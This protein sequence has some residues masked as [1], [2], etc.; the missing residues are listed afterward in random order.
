MAPP[1]R[2]RKPTLLIIGGAEDRVGQGDRA[3]PLR[4]ARGGS[5]GQ[6]R[7]HP[8]GVVLPGRGDRGLHRGL[9]PA[10]RPGAVGRQPP[11]PPGRLT[12]RPLVA[13]ID[14]ATGVFMS[15]GSQ[16]KLSQRFPGT[17]LGDALHRAHDRGA[18]IGGTSA[19]AS[20]MSQF[21]ISMGDE[22]ITP[23][24]RAQ[25]AQRRARARSRAS[26]STSTSPSASRY[27]RLMSMVAASPN[28]IG[29][30]HRRGHRRSRSATAGSSRS[31]APAPSSSSTAARP[32]PTR[33]TPAVER[34]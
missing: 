14:E 29:I 28:L 30:G 6:H 19:G 11:D 22:G 23:R 7:P 20:I 17:P 21:M 1:Q 31:T 25:P 26:S 12:T 8:H 9:H 10:R 5:Q 4:P 27:G 18:V 3:A 34:P 2:R 32:S 15:G 24:Q 33:R 16:L 13:L